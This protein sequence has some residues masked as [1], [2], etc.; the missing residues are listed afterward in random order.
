M[1][2][3]LN[4][5]VSED[6]RRGL[7]LPCHIV[8][9]PCVPGPCCGAFASVEDI[10]LPGSV[11]DRMHQLHL[12]LGSVD[13]VL[14]DS[15]CLYPDGLVPLDTWCELRR[16]PEDTRYDGMNYRGDLE[17]SFELTQTEYDQLVAALGGET[18]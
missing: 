9:M 12:M 17:Y 2:R 5:R 10:P 13:D 6:P 4:I 7:E 8:V 1:G 14:V 15:D 16:W 11:R 3:T 18:Q